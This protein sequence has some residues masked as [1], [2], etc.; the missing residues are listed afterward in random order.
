MILGSGCRWGD[1]NHMLCC[2]SL[3]LYFADYISHASAT[4]CG[5]SEGK[6]G[7]TRENDWRRW[8]LLR[9]LMVEQTPGL[10]LECV[11][12]VSSASSSPNIAATSL[13]SCVVINNLASLTYLFTI[14]VGEL[15]SELK[16]NEFPNSRCILFHVIV[17][18]IFSQNWLQIVTG[19][20]VGGGNSLI[21]FVGVWVFVVGDYGVRQ[22]L[23]GAG[24]GTGG[25][26]HFQDTSI[27]R[28]H[29]LVITDDDQQ[30][31]KRGTRLRAREPLIGKYACEW[32]KLTDPF[33]KPH[34]YYEVSLTKVTKVWALQSAHHQQGDGADFLPFLGRQIV[35]GKARWH[36][37]VEFLGESRHFDGY[38]EWTEDVLS[39]C[40][41]KLHGAGIH[42]PVYASLFTYDRNTEVVKAFCEAWCPL[43][44]TLLT[45]SGEL[46]ISLW[47]LHV[48]VG[49]PLTGLL[50]DEMVPRTD[51]LTGVNKRVEDHKEWTSSKR[52][53]LTELGVKENHQN[54]TYLAAHL[55]CWL[56]SFVLPE[57]DGSLIRPSIFKIAS[58]MASSER[59]SLAVPILASI[60]HGLNKI[61]S[62]AKLSQG[63]SAFPIHFVYGWM[64]CYLRTHFDLEGKR[65]AP[66]M[67]RYSGKGGARFYGPA[68]A[69][70]RVH[71]AELV[72]WHCIM[73]SGAEDFMFIDDENASDLDRGL[74]MA[75]RSNFLAKRI[76]DHFIIEPYSPHRFSRQFGYQQMVPGVL[77]KDIREASL[78]DGL[79]Y[80]RIF[81]IHRS[82]A[83]ACFPS[84]FLNLKRFPNVEYKKWWDRVFDN[85]LERNV[86]LLAQPKP[87]GL[88]PSREE[89]EEANP[90][91]K[92]K[93]KVDP[94]ASVSSNADRHWKREKTNR[95]SSLPLEGHGRNDPS[96]AGASTEELVKEL[97]GSD[98][99]GDSDVPAEACHSDEDADSECILPVRVVTEF[100]GRAVFDDRCKSF[101]KMYWGDLRDKLMRTFDLAH[102]TKS[103]ETLF[104]SATAYDEARLAS[105]EL[106]EVSA[107]H[108]KEVNDHICAAKAKEDEKTREIDL[109]REELAILEEWKKDLTMSLKGHVGSRLAL[110]NEIHG[111]EEE[112]SKIRGSF[113]GRAEKKLKSSKS[114]LE[115]AKKALKDQDPF[116]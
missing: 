32:P 13:C 6:I 94:E 45:S 74:F 51:E 56:C 49:L 58:I 38:W 14:F 68:E 47:D 108:C 93:R 20:C 70:K 28:K 84:L 66:R 4:L 110:R 5:S 81:L 106:D 75:I 27:S 3:D 100:D 109:I 98:D 86:E 69:R 34:W 29:Y 41:D 116:I 22:V 18:V 50:C 15:R 107:Q 115:H 95:K 43:T 44:N 87:G 54:E 10:Q 99:Q 61:S 2:N 79:R 55:A 26:V 36:H 103:L 80:W 60:Y 57:G 62:L 35:E 113:D 105:F 53:P 7:I 46:S 92:G 1:G 8:L 16:A 39:R 91:S 88:L 77:T 63:H 112:L 12:K 76:D 9:P 30:P 42:D 89:V 102:L 19:N 90:S 11:A 17:I 21:A 83:K 23:I 114:S 33:H 31:V 67:V 85:F 82:I 101:L 24:G 64:A 48:M 97:F 59:V 71:R 78:V 111:H 52:A 96:H 40:S 37:K 73:P 104:A 65:E 25:M 72:S